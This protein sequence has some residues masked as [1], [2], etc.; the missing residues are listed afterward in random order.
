[1]V[2]DNNG[3]PIE[4]STVYTEYFVRG[5]EPLDYCDGEDYTY[6]Q[7]SVPAM[8]PARAP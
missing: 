3:V 2:L 7:P 1:V 5:T 4:G 8:V 6:S